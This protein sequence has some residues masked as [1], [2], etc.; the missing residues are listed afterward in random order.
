MSLNSRLKSSS[1]GSNRSITLGSVL[2]LLLVLLTGIAF[3]KSSQLDRVGRHYSEQTS[4][5]RLLSQQITTQAL[6]AANGNGQSFLQLGRLRD[7]FESTLLSLQNGSADGSYPALPAEFLPELEQLNRKWVEFAK[8][9]D[10][11]ESSRESVNKANEA[12]AKAKEQ[13][14]VLL[15]D[16]QEI[17]DLLRNAGAATDQVYLAAQ[18]LTLAQRIDNSLSQLQSGE[19]TALDAA[20]QLN[21]DAARFSLVVDGM[22]NG[23]AENGIRRV[24]ITKVRD[25]LEGVVS[26]FGDIADNASI[27]LDVAPDLYQINESVDALEAQGRELFDSTSRLEATIAEVNK[28]NDFW[29]LLGFI[30]GGVALLT[31]FLL[32]FAVYRVT[33]QQLQNTQEANSRNQKAILTLL[34]EMATLADGDLTVTATVTEDITGAIADSVNYAIEALRSLVQTIDTSAEK[35][36]DTSSQARDSSLRLAAASSKQAQKIESVS[37][38]VADLTRS[39]EKV[40]ENAGLSAEVA[41]QSLNISQKGVEIV[42]KTTDGMD[43]IRENI[44]DTSKRIKRLGESSQEIGD[45]VGLIT[46]IADQTNILA[47]NAAIQA[48]SAGEGGRGFAVVADEVQ[49]LAERASNASKQIEAL[50]RTIQADTNE[51]ISS[52]EKSTANVVSGASQAEEAGGALEEIESVSNRLAEL[53][54]G[55]SEESREQ[56]IVSSVVSEAMGSIREITSENLRSTNETAK[57]IGELAEQAESLRRAADGFKLPGDDEQPDIAELAPPTVEIEEDLQE[58]V[59]AELEEIQIT[60]ESES[61]PADKSIELDSDDEQETALIRA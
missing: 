8:N 49:R 58:A 6:A 59:N 31:F 57:A 29:S 56:A 25:I 12:V 39:I 42:R 17:T 5:L 36:A 10:V 47:L 51:A 16:F 13:L 35:V 27:L 1:A 38:S 53:I 9:I 40:S 45:I 43:T 60:E 20:D 50:V 22:L 54:R 15:Q 24:G 33:R 14:P 3:W 55:I 30:F 11:I 37:E 61:E 23:D 4:E 52:M 46:D 41:D 34:D 48:S 32:L 28:A 2:F 26:R 44:Q 18:Q 19:S 7:R 21:Q